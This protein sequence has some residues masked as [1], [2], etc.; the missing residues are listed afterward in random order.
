MN[1]PYPSIINGNT[2]SLYY[3]I[4]IKGHFGQNWNQLYPDTYLYNNPLPVQSSSQYTVIS[5][6]ANYQVGDEIDIQVEAI[7]GYG[8][9]IAIG[10]PPIPNV[11]TYSSTS[12]INT[13]G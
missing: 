1:Q 11:Y 4:R 6:P 5:L 12:F 2:T 13:S 9:T 3:D 7:L 10:H 8:V